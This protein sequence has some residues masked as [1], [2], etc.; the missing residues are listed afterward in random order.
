MMDA[1]AAAFIENTTFDELSVGDTASLSHTVTQRDIDLFATVTGDVNP[2]Y[3]D[4]AYA[5]TDIF[6]HIIIHGM[7]GGGL[8]SAAI[9]TKLPGPGAIYL[10]QNLRFLHPIEIGDTVTVTLTVAE[11]RAEKYEVTLDCVCTNQNDVAVINGTAYVRA[12][13]N[14][15]QRRRVVLPIVRVGR[16]SSLDAVVARAR[17]GSV[18]ATAVVFPLMQ[19]PCQLR[20]RQRKRD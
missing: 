1:T 2:A 14:K 6:H 20:W 19:P 12:S 3:V 5:A 11:K 15:I 10:G 13:E 16:H 9:G 4:P 8:I 18:V 17:T 7:W